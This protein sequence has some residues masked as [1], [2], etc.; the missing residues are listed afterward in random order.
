MRHQLDVTKM[1]KRLT[2][3]RDIL[4]IMIS[5]DIAAAARYASHILHI[6]GG[7]FFGTAADYAASP[8]GRSYLNLGGGRA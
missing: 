6:G 5:H 8:V 2:E 4:V 7:T 1:L 3:E